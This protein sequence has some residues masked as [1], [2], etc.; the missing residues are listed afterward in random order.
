MSVKRSIVTDY[1]KMNKK[2]LLLGVLKGFYYRLSLG[3]SREVKG[4]FL[5]MVVVFWSA[6]LYLV[7]VVFLVSPHLI[8]SMTPEQSCVETID[9]NFL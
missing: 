7:V 4:V 1:S 6:L 8:G 3:E 9:S 2:L 5:I